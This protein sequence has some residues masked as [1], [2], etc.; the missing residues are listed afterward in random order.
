MAQEQ[1]ATT[2]VRSYSSGTR[3]RILC[4]ARNQHFVV[5]ES[6]RV[7]GPGEAI[8]P[9]EAFLSGISACAVGMVERLANESQLPLRG[10]DVRVEATRDAGTPPAH[11]NVTVFRKLRL[12]I[13]LT[14][15][16]SDQAQ[17]LVDTYKRR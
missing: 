13:S 4:N 6:R 14:G 1:T 12:E 16:S 10:A 17:G 2:R 3:G 11:E 15:L 5:D 8:D 9:I 7:G